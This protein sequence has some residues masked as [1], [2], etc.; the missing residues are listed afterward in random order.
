MVTVRF[1]RQW[2][3]RW[4]VP[5]LTISYTT[6]RVWRGPGWNTI[7]ALTSLVPLAMTQAV[8]AARQWDRALT[9]L[10]AGA[11]SPTRPANFATKP[12]TFPRAIL[13]GPKV[14][15]ELVTHFRR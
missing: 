2:V 13:T 8:T 11:S 12:S 15:M 4:T 10:T 9:V 3:P 14:T 7:P 5:S 1:G 6:R